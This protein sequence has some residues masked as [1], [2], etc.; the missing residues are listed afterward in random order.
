MNTYDL[1]LLNNTRDTAKFLLYELR[2]KKRSVDV[3]LYAVINDM[4]TVSNMP[5]K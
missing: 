3:K 4:R 5:R 2:K 1:N